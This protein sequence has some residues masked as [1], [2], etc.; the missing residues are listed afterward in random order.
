VRVSDVTDE[1][2]G[3]VY[4]GQQL[5][6]MG[7]YDQGGP[8]R[9]T[10]DAR[11]TGQDKSYTTEFSFPETASDHPEL[12]RIWALDRIESLETQRDSGLADGAEVEAAIRDLGLDYQLV[13]DFTSMVVLSDQAFADRG[14][15]RRNGRRIGLERAAQARRAKAP[16]VS[17]R[18]DRSQPM[19][20]RPAPSVRPKRRSGGGGAFDPVTVLIVAGLGGAAVES[21]RRKSK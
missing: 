6:V 18:V 1:A 17:S 21:R 7:R 3:K 19:F 16:A 13:T 5:V 4:R 8:A 2:I 9:V 20:D 14:I 11:L 10:L 15:E 12:E